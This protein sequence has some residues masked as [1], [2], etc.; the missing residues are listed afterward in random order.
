ML[1]YDNMCIL[2]HCNLLFM[3]ASSLKDPIYCI[4]SPIKQKCKMDAN[5]QGGKYVYL[6][7]Y[8]SIWGTTCKNSCPTLS[9]MIETDKDI[10]YPLFVSMCCQKLPIVYYPTFGSR[11]HRPT[12]IS[13]WFV[14]PFSSAGSWYY[15]ELTSIWPKK[16]LHRSGYESEPEV[17][18]TL[19]HS[20]IMD[21][22]SPSHMVII[23]R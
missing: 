2:N 13:M 20:W 4:A 1:V 17:P 22:D 3:V 11:S 15:I 19:S 8:M 18:G 16:L 5:M 23:Y 12:Q 21:V 9:S 10:E 6:Y 7:N 14:I